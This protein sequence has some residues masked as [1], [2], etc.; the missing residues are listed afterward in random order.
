MAVS[1]LITI[2]RSMR[3]GFFTNAVIHCSFVNCLSANFRTYSDS[4]VLTRS[5]GFNF[6]FLRSSFN[7]F[8]VGGVF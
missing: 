4:D 5:N 1:S 2:G 7:S 3:T 8:F 6:S